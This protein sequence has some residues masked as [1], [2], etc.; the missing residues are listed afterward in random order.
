[1]PV[2]RNQARG[3]A[4]MSMNKVIHGAVRRDLTRFITAVSTFQ[5]GDVKRDNQLAVAWSSFDDQLTRHQRVSMRSRGRRS[6]PSGLARV[7]CPA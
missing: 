6:R 1:M 4:E 3:M 2:C 7:S 5:P